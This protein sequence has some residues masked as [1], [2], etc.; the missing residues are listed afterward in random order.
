M[1]PKVLFNRIYSILIQHAGAPI[2]PHYRESFICHFTEG[3]PFGVEWRFAGR[4]GFG[5]KFFRNDRSE[6]YYVTCY[7]EDSNSERKAILAKVNELLKELPY[8]EP[9]MRP[10]K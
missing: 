8:Y 4:L 6:H 5:G 3:P 10:Q 9:N 2:S 7:S 1:E